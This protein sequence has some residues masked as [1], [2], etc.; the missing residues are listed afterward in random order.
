[1]KT[2]LLNT[3]TTII[4]ILIL[5]LSF[6][7]HYNLRYYLRF[8]DEIG[9]YYL[10]N[11]IL[12]NEKLYKNVLSHH[13]P[14]IYLLSALTEKITQPENLYKYIGYQ[15]MSIFLY[16]LF[17]NIIYFLFFGKISL[18]FILLFEFI[19]L[20]YLGFQNLGETLAVY[21]LVFLIGSIYRN[22]IN[23][24]TDYFDIFLYSFANFLAFFSLATLWPALFFLFLFKFTLLTNKKQKIVLSVTSVFLVLILFLFVP[25]F[26]FIRETIYNNF[27]YYLPS[28][29]QNTNLLLYLFFPFQSF[30]PPYDQISIVIG[31]FTII[32]IYNLFISYKKDRKIFQIL[33]FFIFIVYLLNTRDPII[34]FETFPKFHLL[35]WIGAYLFVNVLTVSYLI[36]SNKKISLLILISIIITTCFLILFKNGDY[37]QK[38]NFLNDFYVGYSESEKYGRIINLLKKNNDKLLVIPNDPLIYYLTNIKP[39]IRIV[40]Y[41]SWMTKLETDNQRLINLFKYSP[42]KFIVDTGLDKNNFLENYVLENLNK[43]YIVLK[44]L[45]ENSRLYIHKDKAKSIDNNQKEKMKNL[46]FSF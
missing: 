34:K 37:Y 11:L 41:Y 20:F 38:R 9:H 42:P 10:G 29:K 21:P 19:K 27:K 5:S 43:N 46:L 39:P 33:I 6:Y 3:L 44:H 35:P 18:V 24:K 31:L 36:K 1:M 14:I 17:W 32:F 4:F 13:Q 2:K 23:K 26:D 7:T 30:F 22:Y 16:S 12:R 40:E 15:R 8:G 25:F 28:F 45:N